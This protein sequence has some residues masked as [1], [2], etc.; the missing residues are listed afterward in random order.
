MRPLE[1]KI[2]LLIDGPNMYPIEFKEIKEIAER[3]G[4]IV[5]TEVYLNKHA[6]RGLIEAA[7]N[8]GY[9]PVIEAIDDIDTSLC[10]RATEIICSPRYEQVD[11]IAI[12]SCD[13]DYVPLTHKT[14][15]YGKKC[16]A[17][18]SDTN[19]RSIALKNSVDYLE[20]INPRT[21]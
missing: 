2:A 5:L 10:T 19:G 21:E 13:G 20:I 8:G 15:E 7:I 1:H 18:M 9:R 3:Y 12:A 4:T 6:S 14:K 17:I 11:L 16:L